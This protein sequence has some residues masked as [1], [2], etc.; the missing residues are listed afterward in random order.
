M[1]HRLRRRYGHAHKGVWPF[2]SLTAAVKNARDLGATHYRTYNAHWGLG[3]TFLKSL[4]GGGFEQWEVTKNEGPGFT[5][6]GLA[7]VNNFDIDT[8]P[9]IH[10]LTP[11][12]AGDLAI[13]LKRSRPRL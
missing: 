2:S 13:A 5:Q 6:Y 10:R 9:S 1:R 4:P 12:S 8:H 3:I 11:Q 7:R